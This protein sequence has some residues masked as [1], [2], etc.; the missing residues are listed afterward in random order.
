M[1]A[2]RFDLDRARRAVAE[3]GYRGEPVVVLA[4]TDVPAVAALSAVGIDMLRRAGLTVD[5]QAMDWGSVIRRLGSREPVS[6]GGW[7]AYFSNWAG[8]DHIDPAGHLVLRGQ[9][10]QGFIGWPDSPRLE[11][12]R[13]QWFEA[14][15]LAA[16]RAV[17]AEMQAQAFMDVPYVP[18]GQFF[19]P[20]A[21][22]RTLKGVAQPGGIPRF[23][24]VEMG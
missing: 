3:S 6:R 19:Q 1:E 23:W 17:A 13:E 14:P 21:Y 20:M 15:D 5:E 9:G 24:G 4:A 16:Q 12:L 18:L 2:M 7:S 22:R 10:A 8:L 11:A